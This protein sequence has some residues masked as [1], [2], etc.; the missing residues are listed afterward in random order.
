MFNITARMPRDFISLVLIWQIGAF[1]IY[2]APIF[3]EHPEIAK[4]HDAQSYTAAPDWDLIES[5][6]FAIYYRP[7]VD[8]NKVEADLRKRVFYFNPAIR[9]P[10]AK[11]EDKVAYRVDSLFSRVKE[12]LDMYPQMPKLNMRIFKNKG[13]LEEEYFKIFNTREDAAS[14]YVHKY[15]TIYMSEEGVSD[16]VIAHE[17]AHAV[18]DHYFAVIPPRNV[19]EVLAAYVDIHL[20]E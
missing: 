9:R 8:L 4:A 20:E 7:S 2:V 6:S 14:F 17:M 11:I 5:A 12:L 13:E 15:N 1:A 10:E 19:A 3:G 16:S 18:I